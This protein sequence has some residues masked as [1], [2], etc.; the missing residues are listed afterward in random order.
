MP[1]ASV[2]AKRIH[3]K[4]GCS[5]LIHPKTAAHHLEGK[6][7]LSIRA[8][9]SSA[10]PLVP[11][12]H[13]SEVARSTTWVPPKGRHCVYVTEDSESEEETCAL[14]DAMDTS[15]EVWIEP[16]NPPEPELGYLA[17]T[18]SIYSLYYAGREAHLTYGV[19]ISS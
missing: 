11:P 12:G 10:R 3:C 5:E 8:S 18:C 1:K 13:L 6:A 15:E 17:G 7:G 4:C 19:C 9:I 2:S 16:G 14:L